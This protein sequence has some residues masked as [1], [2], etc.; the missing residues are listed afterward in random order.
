MRRDVIEKEVV[1]CRDNVQ[2]YI[3]SINKKWHVG[4]DSKPSCVCFAFFR[5]VES[6]MDLACRCGCADFK[7]G[8]EDD[9]MADEDIEDVFPGLANVVMYYSEA[10]LDDSAC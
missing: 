10:D 5:N 4:R 2:R 9:N 3:G 1:E 8:S 7:G 6:G